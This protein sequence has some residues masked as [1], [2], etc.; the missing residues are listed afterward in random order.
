MQQANE[1]TPQMMDDVLCAAFEGGSNYWVV[2]VE[3]VG[4]RPKGARYV[5]ECVS[6]GG[7]LRIVESCD[8]EPEKPHELTADALRGG[9]EAAAVHFGQ[10]IERWYDNHDAE[11]ADC[12]LQFALFGELVYG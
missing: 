3:I 1:I 11:A 4:Q 7:K 2:R 9:I 12:A 5:S 6:R 10:T 8:G